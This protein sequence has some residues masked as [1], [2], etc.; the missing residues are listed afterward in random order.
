MTKTITTQQIQERLGKSFNDVNPL[1]SFDTCVLNA[2]SVTDARNCWTGSL[3]GLDLQVG[4]YTTDSQKA[5]KND[6]AEYKRF[7]RCFSNGKMVGSYY[8]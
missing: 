1:T 3:E 8:F 6:T 5:I 2:S 7:V 4:V